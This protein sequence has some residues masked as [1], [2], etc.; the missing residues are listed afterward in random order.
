MLEKEKHSRVILVRFQYVCDNQD[1]LWLF[2]NGLTNRSGGRAF[3]MIFDDV[4]EI[5][6]LEEY[7]YCFS[8]WCNWASKDRL[9]PERSDF[10]F[11][12]L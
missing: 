6:Q 9:E 7:G 5:A 1:K 10:V 4:M 12:V 3:I 11:H 2:E 8:N